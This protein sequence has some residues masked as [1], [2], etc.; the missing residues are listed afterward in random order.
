[1]K[2]VKD[3]EATILSSWR[4]PEIIN[5][6]GRLKELDVHI[7]NLDMGLNYERLIEGATSY[8]LNW[9]KGTSLTK[10]YYE[11]DSHG[12]RCFGPWKAYAQMWLPLGYHPINTPQLPD[13]WQPGPC[14]RRATQKQRYK[15]NV[16]NFM[17]SGSYDGIEALYRLL[18]GVVTDIEEFYARSQLAN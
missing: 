8:P 10:E 5:V 18:H 13:G 2:E 3:T 12:Y 17:A 9:Y 16:Y 6:F 11:I 1:M 14:W 15:K 4:Y 7:E